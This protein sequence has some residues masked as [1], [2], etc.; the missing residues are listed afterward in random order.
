MFSTPATPPCVTSSHIN[1]S[2]RRPKPPP[3]STRPP[4][5][6]STPTAAPIPHSP[7][8]WF[9][10][11]PIPDDDVRRVR[12]T[13]SSD[14]SLLDHGAGGTVGPGFRGRRPA[15]DLAR[16]GIPLTVPRGDRPSRRALRNDQRLHDLGLLGPDTTYIHSLRTSTRS[17]LVVA[18]SGGT[19]WVA[20]RSNS[21]WGMAG[22]RSSRHWSRTAP[23][24]SIDVVTTVLRDVFCSPGPELSAAPW[25]SQVDGS[26]AGNATKQPGPLAGPAGC[27]RGHGLVAAPSAA[28]RVRDGITPSSEKKQ[29]G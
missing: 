29:H 25:S 13:C 7:D 17:W 3:S 9:G 20:R 26:L 28:R 10:K 15:N 27:C 16:L 18:D 23:E 4:M 19:I 6:P 14:G 8:Y 2:P 11:I 21:K 1:N 5:Q 12:N 24:L 22:S